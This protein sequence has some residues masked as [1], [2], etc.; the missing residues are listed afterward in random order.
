[1]LVIVRQFDV[2]VKVGNYRDS[3][4]AIYYY[5]SSSATYSEVLT[6]NFGNLKHTDTLIFRL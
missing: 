1:M 3:D 2:I 6:G 4:S 5:D